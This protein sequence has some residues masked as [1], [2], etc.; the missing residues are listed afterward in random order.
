MGRKDTIAEKENLCTAKKNDGCK[1]HLIAISI[2]ME[3]RQTEGSVQENL[4]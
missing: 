4:A 3:V 1:A 2:Q